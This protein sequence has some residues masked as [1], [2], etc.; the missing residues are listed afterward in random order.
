MIKGE[1][2]TRTR[3]L[4]GDDGLDRLAASK[5]LV[6][7]IGGVGSYVC[8]ALV[9]AGIGE[10]EL[11]DG[12]IVDVTN[13]N[14]QLIA[15]HSTIGRPKT[16]VAAERML[17]INP[18]VRVRP[19]HCF[20]RPENNGEFD[21]SGFDYIVDAVDDV[22]AKVSI[23]VK[24]AES[25]VPVISSM[26]TG[27]KMDPSAFRIADIWD[28]RI[29]PLARAM[30]RELRR[31]GVGHVK[32]VYSE[33]VPKLS[34]RGTPATISFVPAAAGLLIAAG[35]CALLNLALWRLLATVGVKLFRDL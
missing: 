10:F 8:E 25:G 9:R 7:G 30:R 2:F 3:A 11:V 29:C 35:I 24:A 1:E 31:Y 19:R 5:I 34:Y 6:F 22:E 33:E 12:D 27:N 15:M 13:I 26:G 18:D 4:I 28:T 17:D 14:R 16:D 21:F 32:T 20:Y 23:I